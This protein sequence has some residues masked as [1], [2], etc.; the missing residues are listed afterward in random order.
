MIYDKNGKVIK[1]IKKIY[2]KN[3]LNLNGTPMDM[4]KRKYLYD[5]NK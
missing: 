5:R 2:Y 3:V 4:S 1:E